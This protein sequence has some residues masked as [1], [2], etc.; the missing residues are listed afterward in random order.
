MN[1]DNCT[2]RAGKIFK[3]N[4]SNPASLLNCINDN[5]IFHSLNKNHLP[6]IAC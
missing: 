6:I 2:R 5:I 3:I 1:D 4:A